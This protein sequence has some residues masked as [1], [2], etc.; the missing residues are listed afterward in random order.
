[1]TTL[2]HVRKGDRFL[3]PECMD[4]PSRECELIDINP[5][6]SVVVRFDGDDETWSYSAS[7]FC[8]LAIMKESFSSAPYPVGDEKGGQP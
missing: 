6:G 7:D 2:F 8:A 4:V 5:H 1:M 3:L